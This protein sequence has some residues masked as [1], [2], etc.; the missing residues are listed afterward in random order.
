MTL[1][2]VMRLL[3]LR[4]AQERRLPFEV[5]APNSSTRKAIA[6]LEAGKGKRV[7]D[8]EGLMRDLNAQDC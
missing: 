4:I 3:F 8:V 7:D 6:E 1:R 5:R 2:D